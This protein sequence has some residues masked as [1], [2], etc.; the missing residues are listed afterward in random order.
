MGIIFS[1]FR[2]QNDTCTVNG[3][4]YIQNNIDDIVLEY[5]DSEDS[6]NDESLYDESLHDEETLCDVFESLEE[7]NNN[8]I[9]TQNSN[10][11]ALLIGINYIKNNKA[12][13][14][15]NGC[16]NDVYNLQKMLKNQCHFYDD[17]I[18]TLLN[19]EATKNNIIH[20]IERLVYFSHTYYNSEIWFSYS[21]HGGGKFSLNEEDFQSEFICPSDYSKNGLIN[22]EWIKLNFIN[23]LHP[24]TKCFV[25][26][27]CCN[28][29]SNMNLPYSYNDSNRAVCDETLCKIIKIS[30]SKDDQTSADYFD[31]ESS[32]YQ[33]AL[34]NSFLKTNYLHEDILTHYLETKSILQEN[35]FTQ[36][37]E[38]SY[39]DSKL[40]R[41][42][43][44]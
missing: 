32:S 27:D 25:L 18:K 38:L 20:E 6:L 43:L 39:S 19:G 13:D 28:S 29:G 15:L 34:T 40:V 24:S 5:S 9:F 14:D 16:V 31:R 4:L 42:T 10:K 23:K 30:G 36:V 2:K 21:G 17:N 26:M 37:P 44:Y 22:D 33:G 35:K 12:N 1:L 11:L 8:C 3:N 41:Y 7:T